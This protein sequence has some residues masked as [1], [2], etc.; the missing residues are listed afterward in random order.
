MSVSSISASNAYAALTPTA[1]ASTRPSSFKNL[2]KSL[3]SGDLAGAQ[4]AFAALQQNAPPAAADV[5]SGSG[6]ANPF[7][8]DISAIGKALSAGDLTGAQTAFAKL[9]DDGQA[10]QA[11]KGGEGTQAAGGHHHG[12]HGAKPAAASD[13]P[14]SNASTTSATSTSASGAQIGSTISVK[15]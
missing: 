9:R 1:D 7:A 11:A 6:Q 8:D 10:A 5:S 14:A 3:E 15:V 12:H 2:A 4:T 13:A